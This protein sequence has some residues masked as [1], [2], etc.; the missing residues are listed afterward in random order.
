VGKFVCLPLLL[1]PGPHGPVIAPA[2]HA[3]RLTHAPRLISVISNVNIASPISTVEHDAPYAMT[4]ITF[5]K[6]S[7]VRI[8]VRTLHPN[9]SVK[10]K[11]TD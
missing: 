4:E 6:S 1:A 9:S 7:F 5:E 11:Y 2:L 8:E 10:L 3:L